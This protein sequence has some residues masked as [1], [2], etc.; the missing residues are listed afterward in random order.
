MNGKGAAGSCAI[1]ARSC[2]LLR[3]QPTGVKVVK[4]GDLLS[5]ERIEGTVAC[6]RQRPNGVSAYAVSVS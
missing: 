4:T 5:S 1:E 3:E 2:L 6:H